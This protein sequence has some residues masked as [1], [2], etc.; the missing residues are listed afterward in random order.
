MKK[1]LFIFV[2]LM[3]ILP[4]SA[5]TDEIP[6]VIPTD[7]PTSLN[8]P[9]VAWNWNAYIADSYWANEGIPDPLSTQ[10]PQ[11]YMGNLPTLPI[12]I[13][14]VAWVDDVGLN[15]SQRAMLAQN[16]FVVVPT[17]LDFFDQA[18]SQYENVWDVMNPET[19]EA[20]IERPYWIST[21][22]VLHTLYLNFENLLKFTELDVLHYKMSG[23]LANAY[24]T[25]YATYQGLI[26]TPLEAQARGSAVF[27][28][29]ALGLFA[30]TWED[31][32]YWTVQDEAIRA[33]ADVLIAQAVNAV[34]V[35][36]VPFLN[37]YREDFSRYKPRGHYT[38]D[39][40]LESYFRGMMWL[41]RITFLVKDDASLVSSLF[42][43]KALNESGGLTAWREI[44]DFITFLVGDEDNLGPIQYMPLAE[45]IF[46]VGIPTD[47]LGDVTLLE[48]FRQEVFKLPAPKISNV[49]TEMDVTQEELPDLTRG[50]RFF[51]QRF[52]FDAYV[53]QNLLNPYVKEN[54]EGLVRPLP[55]SLDV[56]S[57]L[58]SDV[59]YELLQARGDTTFDKF[60]GNM[61]MLREEVNTFTAE[62]WFKNIYGGWLWTLQPLFVRRDEAYPPMMSTRAWQLKDLQTGLAS[63]TE[64]KHATVLYAAQPEGRGGG[65]GL[66]PV[67]PT[68][69]VEP[70]PYV[71][72]RIAI[73]AA[74]LQPK[75]QAFAFESQ[76]D[77][78]SV[79]AIS[80]T[81]EQLSVLSARL[82]Y[83]SQKQM[84]GETLTDDEK[85][86]LKYDVHGYLNG[87]RTSL[88]DLV[89]P[90]DR[91]PF[92]AVV[93][94]IATNSD[95]EAV[96]Q[97]GT[98]KIDY[99]YV[100]VTGDDG[101]LQLARGAV[102]SFY[103]FINDINNRL[104]DEQWREMITNGQIPPRPDWTS[105]FIGQP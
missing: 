56:A 79:G 47:S 70:N 78:P 88:G 90:E 4:L 61:T 10:L 100:V 52:T 1:W 99:I 36:N 87:I 63:Y 38:T 98:G 92:S 27:Y 67:P 74:A 3:G 96:L 85:Y 20:E 5:Q 34:D 75:V 58:G 46:G 16:G 103:E 65:G 105:E 81:L 102:Y 13:S 68:S 80:F 93:T 31:R 25:A 44:A 95:I 57:A 91:P 7:N 55:S 104:T 84:F 66:P 26:G 24:Q 15:D 73:V 8:T 42:V 48:A 33:E 12:D 54:P 72:A 97:I 45:L 94:D 86:F 29:V 21:D 101:T 40:T 28:A 43:L 69:F 83:I 59:A 32:S 17:G 23:I 76:S 35:L 53:M 41:G 64:L 18:Y 9:I 62:D 14:Q 49:K 11:T 2:L 50:F 37:D 6:P 82:A 71:F 89:A 51:G 77:Y 19:Y 60:I 39:P 30:S 22:A